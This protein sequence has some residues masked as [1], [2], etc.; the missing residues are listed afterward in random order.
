VF[1]RDPDV[2][3]TM[4]PHEEAEAHVIDLTLRALPPVPPFVVRW[5]AYLFVTD[6]EADPQRLKA[7]QGSQKSEKAKATYKMGSA[8]DRYSQLVENM[9]PLANGRVPEDSEVVEYV[10]RQVHLSCRQD[11]LGFEHHLVVAKLKDPEE[12]KHWLKM[13]VKHKLGK[14]RLRK[15]I[16]F[17]RLATEKEVQGDPAD[18]DYVTYLALINRIRRWWARETGKAPVDEWDEDR[19]Q[20]LKKDFNLVV[21]IHNAL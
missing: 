2:I 4:T 10:S 15:S 6:R 19:R 11:Q 12:Q 18:R 17:G 3:L 1:A 13:A 16:N 20:G 14:R 5:N 7:V 9:P 21:D 8:A